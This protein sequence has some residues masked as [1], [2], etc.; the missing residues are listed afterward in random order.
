MDPSLRRVTRLPL[1]ELWDESG[2]RSGRV[3]RDDLTEDDIRELLRTGDVQFVDIRMSERPNWVESGDTFAFWKEQLQPKL[4]QWGP[5]NRVYADEF[6]VA[7]EW[8]VEG[9]DVP[10][11]V[12][13]L[14]D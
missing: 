8:R 12:A 5:E 13:V 11:V 9:V 7:S 6:Y 3:I 4:T 2:P 14:H 1:T 10:V